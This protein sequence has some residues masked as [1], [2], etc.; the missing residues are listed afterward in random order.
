MWLLMGKCVGDNNQLTALA[1]ALGFRVVAKHI[2]FNQL[3]RLRQ[4]V[5]DG[6]GPLAVCRKKGMLVSPQ[7][8]SGFHP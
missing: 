1:R 6:N 5:A 4:V 7:D 8:A 3:R 2:A